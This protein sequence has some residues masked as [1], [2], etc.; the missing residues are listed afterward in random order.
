[1]AIEYV[2]LAC[3]K[4]A[5]IKES[6]PSTNYHGAAEYE[7]AGANAGGYEKALLLAAFEEL[8]AAYRYRL[9]YNAQFNLTINRNAASA[10]YFYFNTL[11]TDFD[12]ETATWNNRPSN[13]V[14]FYEG[15]G[16]SSG[17]GDENVSGYAYINSTKDDAINA[18][19]TALKA[20]GF[21]IS[22]SATFSG[23]RYANVYTN[24]A[25]SGKRPYLRIALS[26]TPAYV[27]T[28]LVSPE[29]SDRPNAAAPITFSWNFSF[30]TERSK[31]LAPIVQTSATLYWR[32]AGTEDAFQGIAVSG[33]VRSVT[34]PAN[35]FPAVD[36][37]WYVS[38]IIVGFDE[39]DSAK[40][41]ARI[42]R[43]VDMP[44]SGIAGVHSR[45]DPD[46]NYPW[47]GYYLLAYFPDTL[48]PTAYNN[49]LFTTDSFTSAYS[50]YAIEN[51]G[52]CFKTY[53]PAGKSRSALFYC[54]SSGFDAQT[55]TW[56]TKP[57]NDGSITGQR[58]YDNRENPN[59]VNF[60][61]YLITPFY[62][63]TEKEKSEKALA[64]LRSPGFMLEARTEYPAD[65]YNRG[66]FTVWA[67]VFR[68]ALLIDLIVTSKPEGVSNTDGYVN[69]HVAQ[70][71]K[72]EHV[73]DGDYYCYAGWTTASA[74]LYWSSDNGST[75]HSVAA[76][77]NSSEVVLPAET[78]PTGTVKW[79]VTATDDQGTTAT[80]DTY[81]IS[82]TDV[83]HTATPVYPNSSLEN[84]DAPIRFIWTDASD[85]NTAPTGA[86]LQ[87]STNG[88]SWIT[89]AQPRTSATET[90]A[91]A[92]TF[93]AG[94][95]LWRVR[96]LNADGVAGAWSD[97]L[98]FVCFAA[99]DAPII[100]TNGKP[101]LTVTWQSGNQQAYKVIVDGKTYGP[102]FG[103]G[104][105]FTVP[106]FLS[107]G[108][109]TVAV[110]VQ[111]EYSLWSLIDPET[112][113][114]IVSVTVLNVR[115]EPVTLTGLID[116]DAE[117]S[118]ST[119]DATSGFLIYRDDV[120]IGHA[121][122][123]S[124]TDRVV[125][126]YH[127][128]RVINRLPGG[129]YTASNVVSGTLMTGRL[130]IAPLSGGAWLELAKS[131]NSAR[132]VV[133]NESQRVA[134]RQF[135]GQIY[136][137]AEAAPYKTMSAGF[138]VAWT[139]AEAEQ[140]AIFASLIGQPVIFKTPCEGAMVGILTAWQRNN[141]H[142]YR[143][144]SATVQRIHWRDYVDADD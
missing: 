89:F 42:R 139:H 128:W 127:S 37:E 51:A 110:S 11:R 96:S 136:P 5:Y 65:D 107:D 28:D 109:H 143:S 9:I 115:G 120:Q 112:D 69:P 134:L 91:P 114:G 81:T 26:D 118:W 83:A 87:Y 142:F 138:D 45:N 58:G 53:I 40:R 105:S 130:A 43:Y 17:T 36:I 33:D 48:S 119:N 95:V 12:A 116:L 20:P 68:R 121:S 88:Y 126:G 57:A 35:T 7:L 85:T 117:L 82:T 74:T 132:S 4:V 94:T 111:N 23:N 140:A 67:P 10:P 47:T 50:Y 133:W 18:A 131:E 24:A 41:T 71:F 144:Y 49:L 60:N 84:G 137:Q 141:M 34:V 66:Y 92:S 75:W 38:P 39:H 2:N 1:M 13:D 22:C 55:V 135:A 44:A 124:F 64:V 100:S 103:T 72:W 101:M 122:G 31:A 123:R 16:G 63:S 86:D 129:Y 14:H 73:Q 19:Y 32:R 76:E 90:D 78:M 52:I 46:T 80:S 54:L 113:A 77:A 102:Y 29:S 97:P 93:P 61:E 15:A 104:K 21:E 56:N 106:D 27:K 8:P 62:S 108:T 3:T 98:S 70:T 6:T 79:Y 25:A 99:P 59:D 125:L 30:L